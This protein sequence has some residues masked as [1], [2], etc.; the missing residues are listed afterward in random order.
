MPKCQKPKDYCPI[1]FTVWTPN[2]DSMLDYVWTPLPKRKHAPLKVRA[3][4]VG[5]KI[6]AEELAY[7]R[8]RLDA[9]GDEIKAEQNLE[10]FR[11][12]L[13]GLQAEVREL[14]GVTL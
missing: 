10:Q 8:T 11:Q 4:R 13:D 1:T 3:H 7:L 9:I 14:L 2:N 5:L 6:A 12:E